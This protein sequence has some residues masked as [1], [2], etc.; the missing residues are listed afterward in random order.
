M[1]LPCGA[2]AT[3]GTDTRTRHLERVRTG[4]VGWINSADSKATAI[5]TVGG[6]LLALLAAVL[7]V[8]SPTERP[9]KLVMPFV[10]FCIADFVSIAFAAL[11][12]YPRVN[13][14]AILKD[15]GWDNALPTSRTFFADIAKLSVPEFRALF[16]QPDDEATAADDL[17]QA[18]VL[19]HIAS[20]KMY[21]IR[22]SIIA[23]S[24]SLA[25]LTALLVI[26]V[27]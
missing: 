18:F 12:V 17:E 27:I 26:A 11:V 14:E 3:D 8:S 13:R 4:A 6:A 24:V 9:L 16:A 25:A 1:V 20:R 21:A 19:Q 2:M 15:S 23:L 7:A 10:V 5:L 22:A